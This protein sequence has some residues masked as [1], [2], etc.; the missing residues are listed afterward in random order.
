MREKKAIN[1][2]IGKRIKESRQR[3]GITQEQLSE[4]I[5]VS[6]QYLSDLERGLVGISI[7]TLKQVCIALCT[8]SDWILFGDTTQ[9]ARSVINEKCKNLSLEQLLLIAEIIDNF[10]IK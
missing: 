9:D 3:I 7:A 6:T 2:E 1:I 8:S 4:A 5:D 10:V